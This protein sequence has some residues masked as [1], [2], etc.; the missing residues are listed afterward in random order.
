M[1]KKPHVKSETRQLQDA[2][3]DLDI[4]IRPED[5]GC[6]VPCDPT[7]CVL[8]QAITRITGAQRV[9]VHRSIV[10]AV[11]PVG[12]GEYQ[13][14]RWRLREGERKRIYHFDRTGEWIGRPWVKLR[15]TKGT[16]NSLEARRRYDRLVRSGAIK[17]KVVGQ[18]RPKSK[19]RVPEVREFDRTVSHIG[20]E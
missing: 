16:G 13:P 5:E 1:D 17:P 18:R 6:A 11:V 20:D 7:R 12:D 3:H 8:A 2:E 10:R 9:E 19:T 4:Y 14:L 15:A